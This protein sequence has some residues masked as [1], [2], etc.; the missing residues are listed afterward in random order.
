[1]EMVVFSWGM[2]EVIAGQD[3]CTQYI[4]SFNP[5][6][7]ITYTKARDNLASIL[8]ETS[9]SR[10]AMV[11]RRRGHEDVAVIPAD[12]LSG[13]LETAHLLRS[14]ANASR[15]LE[16]LLRSYRGGGTEMTIDELG[17][18]VGIPINR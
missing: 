3:S 14:P 11:I 13:L 16:A 12:E 10:E 4:H 17:T 1:M 5:M 8:D 18:K 6:K 2:C 15:L 7:T 9:S